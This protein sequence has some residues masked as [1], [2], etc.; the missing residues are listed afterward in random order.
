MDGLF[1]Q[2]W[3]DPALD[4]KELLGGFFDALINGIQ[5]PAQGGRS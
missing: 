1:L 2:C 5:D 3:F 4:A